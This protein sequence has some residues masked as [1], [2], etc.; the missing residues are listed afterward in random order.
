MISLDA[1]VV[2]HFGQ[3]IKL[4]PFA[5]AL[6]DI[7]TA[8]SEFKFAHFELG[9]ALVVDLDYGTFKAEAQLSPNSYILNPNC[10]PTHP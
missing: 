5:V 10:H 4:G 3:A 1:V 2:M 8:A 9:I 7:P 6:V